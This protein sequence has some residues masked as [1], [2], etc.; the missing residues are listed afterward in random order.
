MSFDHS[1]RIAFISGAGSGIGR[2]VGRA[3][4]DGARQ[5]LR[6]IRRALE[7]LAQQRHVVI[8]AGDGVLLGRLRVE[9]LRVTAGNGTAHGGWL[10]VIGHSSSDKTRMTNDQRQMTNDYRSAASG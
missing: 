4:H 3:R 1:G 9:R 2:A 5:R 10:L 6:Q 8:D 7:R